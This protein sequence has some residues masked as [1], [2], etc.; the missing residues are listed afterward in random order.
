MF[1]GLG[2]VLHREACIEE[3]LGKMEEYIMMYLLL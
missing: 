2:R 3:R 1:E